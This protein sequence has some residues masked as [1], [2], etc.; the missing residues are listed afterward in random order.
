MSMKGAAG[1]KITLTVI[2]SLIIV[3]M[4]VVFQFVFGLMDNTTTYKM[5]GFLPFSFFLGGIL[6]L[7]S[8]HKNSL[9][10][11]ILICG[12]FI[13]LV[14]TPYFFALGDYQSFYSRELITGHIKDAILFLGLEF[15]IIVVMT[16]LVPARRS[17]ALVQRS[18]LKPSNLNGLM[19][20]TLGLCMFLVFA[21]FYVPEL[22]E[23]YYPFYKI[24]FSEVAN[25]RWDNETLVPRGGLARYVYSLFMFL[26]PLV[27]VL[28]PNLLI[29][30]IHARYGN[31]NLSL[32]CALFC[33]LVPFLLLGG[34]NIAPLIGMLFC[35]LSIHKLYGKKAIPIMVLLGVGGVVVAVMVI[36]SKMELYT[37]WRGA[38][39]ISAFSQILYSYFPSFDNVALIMGMNG[40]DKLE[41][42]FFDIYSGIPFANT[43]FGLEGTRLSDLF[44]LHARTNGQIEEWGS[45]LGYYFSYFLAPI[46]SGLFFNLMLKIEAVSRKT[47]SYWKYFVTSFIAVYSAI[48][49]HIYSATIYCR[50]I[51]N[52]FIPIILLSY[53]FG[54]FQIRTGENEK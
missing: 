2:W 14:L 53:L 41:T 10:F 16:F 6:A 26:W 50:L 54:A 36:V 17:P 8:P 37:V 51:F 5:L 20:L 34:D 27:R 31:R 35:L 3:S 45:S 1:K 7:L 18:V 28:L 47:Q 15:I 19:T 44:A 39:G 9:I 38:T 11:L 22:Q 32:F 33:L 42:L 43:L 52:I 48:A 25:I 23:I 29:Y 21:W 4:I 13:K 24:D 30:K 46:L 49:I 40:G 12:F